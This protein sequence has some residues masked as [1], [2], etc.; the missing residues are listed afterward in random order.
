MGTVPVT[1]GVEFIGAHMSK[2]LVKSG[3]RV[4]VLADG[5]TFQDALI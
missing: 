1:G 4:V 2:W 5:F 3:Y